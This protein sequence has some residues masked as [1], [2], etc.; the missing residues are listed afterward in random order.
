MPIQP[1]TYQTNFPITAHQLNQ[2]MYTYDGSYFNSNGVMFHSNRPLM[3][4]SYQ[5][6]SI[7]SAAKTGSLTVIGGSQGDAISILDNAALFGLGADFPGNFATFW[8]VGA[9]SPGSAGGAY[10]YGGWAWLCTFLPVGP[11]S[12][13]AS[14]YGNVWSLGVAGTGEGIT[15]TLQ[16]IG[17][18]QP[19]SATQNNCGFA[20]DL[21]ER[22]SSSATPVQ[23]YAPTMFAVDAAG[24]SNALVSNTA[25]ST[26]QTPRFVEIWMGVTPP[27]GNTVATIPVPISTVATSTTFSSSTLNTTINQ[28]FNLLNNPPMLNVQLQNTSTIASGAI[29]TVPFTTT[30]QLDNYSGFSTASQH[31]IVPLSGMYLCHANIIYN[32]GFNVGSGYVGFSVNTNTLAGGSYNATPSGAINTGISCTKVIGLNQGD[33]VSVFTQLNNGTDFANGNVSRFLMGWMS[34]IN[35]TTQSWTPPDVTGFQFQAG[36]APGTAAS[37]LVTIM[38]TKLAN[39]INFLLNRPYCQV[40]QTTA[41]TGLANTTWTSIL[42]QSTVTQIHGQ[43]QDNYNGWNAGANHYVAPVNGWYLAVEE[44]AAATTSTANSHFQIL[45]GFSV[46]T[47]GGVTSPTSTGGSGSA[48]PDVYQQI[49]VANGGTWPSGATGMGLYYLLAGETIAPVAKYIGATWATDTTHN[50]ASHFSVFWMSN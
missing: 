24:S 29:T 12:S 13:T 2:D 20:L 49:M 5:V 4:E 34:P 38:N 15:G 22:I 23:I 7:V 26:G 32:I 41:Q 19:G 14:T 28:T 8:S 42:M 37:G 16:D 44:I 31:Y 9:I 47:S 1:S 17:C 39:D 36:N 11:F 50:F 35:T 18:M 3:S 27:Y 43:L 46:P 10:I 21:V 25:T 40:H 30:P 45:A 48:P 33:T 6:N